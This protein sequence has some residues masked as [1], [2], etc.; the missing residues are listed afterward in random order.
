MSQK[1]TNMATPVP[2]AYPSYLK[3][4]DHHSVLIVSAALFSLHLAYSK[5]S[6]ELE[7][8]RHVIM[9]LPPN[10]LSPTHPALDSQEKL[11]GS[12]WGHESGYPGVRHETGG[13]PFIVS[14]LG[15]AFSK[16]CEANT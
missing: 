4:M 3:T 8:A 12:K 15:V 10:C 6:N 1:A 5:L 16:N 7:Q 2:G 14:A 13:A 9:C 11:D